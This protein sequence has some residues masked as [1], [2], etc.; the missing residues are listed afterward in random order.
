[1]SKAVTGKYV[2]TTVAGETVRAFVPNPLPPKLTKKD[3]ASLQEPIRAAEAA[4]ERLRLAGE[5]IPS[6]DWFVYSFVRKE[7]LLTSEIEG[8]QATLA[9][10]MSYEQTG[11]SGSS[12]IADVEEVTNY[13]RAANYAFE[14]LSS[15]K[16]LPVSSRLLD[17][18]H[19]RLMQ[20]VRGKNKQP[21]EIRRSQV[22]VG[23]TRP[24]NAIFVPPPWGQV[25]GLLGTL[26]TYIHSDDDLPPLLRIAAA[27][28]QFET[29]HPYL[30]GNG[31]IGRLLIALLL[32]H[33]HVLD[34]PLLYLS[35]Y[36]KEHQAEYYNQLGSIRKNGTWTDWFG[37]FLEGT[38]QIAT[39]AAATATS[40]NKQ[41][42]GDRKTVI[43]AESVTVSAIQLFEAL[44]KHPVISMPLVTRILSTS[45]PTASKAID[46]LIRQEILTEIGD[47][48]RD[49]IYK[50]DKYLQ[51]LD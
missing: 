32:A 18:C 49:R 12:D 16:G 39:I 10:V 5:M 40:L 30:D 6:V 22:W 26:E 14:Q 42:N 15:E 47:R 9:D 4:L 17:E 48:K 20:G 34:A 29:I 25:R 36:L 50:Y 3:L 24:S 13:V 21:G 27:H 31:R 28:V 7:A 44:P 19:H 51:I 46:L 41:V 45:K 33:W 11:Q 43:S 37:F 35:V 2:E 1:M 38:K 23:G 8:T